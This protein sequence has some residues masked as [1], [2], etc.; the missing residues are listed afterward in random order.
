M[1]GGGAAHF[2][3][4]AYDYFL[5]E[6]YDDWYGHLSDPS[7]GPLRPL[8]IM[9]DSFDELARRTP[10]SIRI[11]DCA[12]GTGNLFRSL[13][14]LGYDTWASDGS[15]EM[16][17]KA[18][19]NCAELLEPI[20]RKLI[21]EPI[22]WAD[23][24][25]FDSLRER[26]GLFD[27]VVVASNSFCHMPAT[28]EY[29]QVALKNLSNILRPGGR[30][31]IDTKRYDQTQSI[32]GVPIFRELRF[33]K[34]TNE[35]IIRSEREETSNIDGRAVHFHTRLHYD[36]DPAF[37]LCRALIAITRYGEG[38]TPRTMVMPYYPLP[39][40]ELE[41]R[42]KQLEFRTSVFPAMNPPTNWSYD[43]VIGQKP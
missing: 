2:H 38:Q 17:K 39:A 11:L 43:F 27:I 8:R 41:A 1:T 42:M 33:S 18:V 32:D 34:D 31:L 37:K 7:Q 28:D 36:I 23:K 21:S 12:C 6:V 4:Q 16:L 20:R 5:A 15:R 29:M 19:D 24:S 9:M 26:A 3:E 40:E 25:A 35:W 10:A 13:T 22:R 14:A 30:L